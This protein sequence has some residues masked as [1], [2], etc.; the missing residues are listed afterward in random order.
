MKTITLHK[1]STFNDRDVLQKI[2]S[3]HKVEG[4]TIF[5]MRSIVKV[6]DKLD[7]ETD[8]MDL[9][10]EEYSTLVKYFEKF[11]FGIAHPDVC[12]LY[13]SIM[14]AEKADKIQHQSV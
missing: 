1:R 9:E 7:S 4:V 12:G 5:E 6:L 14:A 10:D 13:D 3:E 8:T 11:Q 2:L